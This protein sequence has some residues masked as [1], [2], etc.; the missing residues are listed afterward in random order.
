MRRARAAIF[1]I[2]LAGHGLAAFYIATRREASTRSADDGFLTSIFFIENSLQRSAVPLSRART[3]PSRAARATRRKVPALPSAAAPAADKAHTP[4]VIDSPPHPQPAAADSLEAAAQGHRRGLGP[5]TGA[6][7]GAA[8]PPAIRRPFNWDYARTHR[9]EALPMGGTLI[10]LTD[11]CSLVFTFPILI[12]TC[13]LGKNEA[14]AD[15]FTHM[16]D[17][18][19][20]RSP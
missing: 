9:F 6:I 8:Q 12:G 15:L 19:D 14:R 4:I 10:N 17:A 1:L 18:E 5:S 3:V 13:R 2:V 20:L 11:R 16:R 7:V